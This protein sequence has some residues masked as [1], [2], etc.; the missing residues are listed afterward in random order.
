MSKAAVHKDEDPTETHSLP[1]VSELAR[2]KLHN[3]ILQQQLC[4]EQLNGLVLQFLQTPKPKEFQDKLENLTRQVNEMAA[5][6]YSS[7]GVDPQ[8]Y[9]F[10]VEKG[11]FVARSEIAK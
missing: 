3:F 4:R 8:Q 2:L 6:L 1:E 5:D 9:Q 10:D 7:T 11:V